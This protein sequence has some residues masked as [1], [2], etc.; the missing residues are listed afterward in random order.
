MANSEGGLWWVDGELLGLDAAGVRGDDS[1]FR[2]GRGCY[3]TAAIRGGR[4]RWIDRHA[5][6]LR[7]DAERLGIGVID[8]ERVE[9]ALC[10]LGAAAFPG[11]DGIVRVQAS[12]DARGAMHVVGLARE[13]GPDTDRWSAVRAPF[14]HEG[15]VPWS[16]AKVTNHLLFAMARDYAVSRGADEAV[17]FDAS[18]R[19]IEGA[20]SNLLV[21]DQAG[22]LRT[23]DLEAG[24]VR[25]VA[26]E[27]LFE[28]CPE[29]RPSEIREAELA[30]ARELIATNSVRGALAI[31]SF[32]GQPV[33]DCE[34]GAW[35]QRL[36]TMLREAR[37]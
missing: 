25:G 16:G 6:R 14:A 5:R 7:R 28:Q 31:V 37:R 8:S 9:Q 20:R 10:E 32:D 1:A 2:E 21:V 19:L 3:T 13:S 29:L 4:P 35:A 12:R 33:G 24:G 27:I 23:P 15:R 30:D 17:L 22:A 34:P 26:L 18:G 36:D 11:R